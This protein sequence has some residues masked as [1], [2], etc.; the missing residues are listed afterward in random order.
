VA[1]E[2]QIP[3]LSD[4]IYYNVVHDDSA[5]FHSFGN[6]TKDVPIICTSGISKIYGVPG[7]RLGWIIFYNH[8][9]YFDDVI[10]G[11]KKLMMILLHPNTL[12]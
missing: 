6:L 4:E 1:K 2:L 11:L 7:W 3:I 12:V 8:H 9:N 5:T 10:M